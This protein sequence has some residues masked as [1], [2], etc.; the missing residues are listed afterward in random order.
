VPGGAA[1]QQPNGVIAVAGLTVVVADLAE[2][3]AELQEL[4]GDQW[5]TAETSGGRAMRFP[6]GSQWIQVLQPGESGP[7]AEYLRRVGE[8]PYEVELSRG[9]EAA[10]GE[11]VLLPGELHGARLRINR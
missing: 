6:I 10:P 1:T 8:G 2:A 9:G 5:S 3:G 7:A 11:G 4:L